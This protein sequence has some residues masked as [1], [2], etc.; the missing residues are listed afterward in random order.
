M[1]HTFCPGSKLLRQPAPEMYTCPSCG[2]EVEIWTDE[3]KATC[4]NCNRTVYRDG[5]MGCLDW[6]AYGKE[7]VGDAVFET[8]MKN[9]AIGLKRQLIEAMAQHF[10]TDHKRI[11]HAKEVLRH[12]EAIVEKEGGD[13]HVVAAAAVLHD[14]GIK[15][16]EEHRAPS[17]LTHEEA[18]SPIA[19]KIL[20]RLGFK[21]EDVDQICRIIACHH[22]RHE[23]DGINF[24]IV[25][26][27]D[28]IVNLEDMAG[29]TSAEHLRRVIEETLFTNT[30][31]KLALEKLTHLPQAAHR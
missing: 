2:E 31:R 23:G 14:V 1:D 27:A 24:G 7:C 6:C 30:G 9:K 13:S 17:G 22:R 25:Y 8:Y 11:Q 12:A 10:E 3:L 4:R 28:F 18:G 15:V 20:L 26:D 5:T 19:R 29:Q 16:A 21:I